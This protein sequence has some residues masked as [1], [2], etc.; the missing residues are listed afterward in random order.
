MSK[1]KK[2]NLRIVE[3]IYGNRKIEEVFQE[4]YDYYGIPVKVRRKTPEEL[5]TEKQQE[6][7]HTQE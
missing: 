4:I 1:N 3:K 7:K 5:V 6:K 2:T